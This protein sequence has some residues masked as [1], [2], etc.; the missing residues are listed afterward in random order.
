MIE[1]YNKNCNFCK[2][3]FLNIGDK[4]NYGGIVIYKIGNSFKD[5]WFATLS[6]KTGGDQEKDFSI[7]LMPFLHIRYFSEINLYPELAKNY[8]IAF[9]RLCYAVGKIIG[10][11]DSNSSRKIPIGI[12]GKCKHEDEHIHFKIFPYRGNIGQPFTVDSSFEKKEIYLDPSTQEKFV[13]MTPIKKINISEKKIL[14]LSKQFMSLL[15]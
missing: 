5:S 10:D 15:K 9:S 11:Q 12:Y 7:Q 6:P 13:K 1:I 4:T 8:G 2:E 14:Q 3:A